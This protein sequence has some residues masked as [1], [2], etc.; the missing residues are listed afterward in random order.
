MITDTKTYYNTNNNVSQYFENKHDMNHKSNS[1]SNNQSLPQENYNND[2]KNI[3]QVKKRKFSNFTPTNFNS[4]L[5][6]DHRNGNYSS[7]FSNS[8]SKLINNKQ[9]YQNPN[10]LVVPVVSAS[11]STM[12]NKRPSLIRQTS[13]EL[14]NSSKTSDIKSK[15]KRLELTPQSATE[16]I[17]KQKQE[18]RSQQQQ[19]DSTKNGGSGNDRN[20]NQL[21]D[22]CYKLWRFLKS[23]IDPYFEHYEKDDE[24]RRIYAAERSLKKRKDNESKKHDSW[25]NFL[26]GI[27]TKKTEKIAK[28]NVTTE[29]NKRSSNN[30]ANLSL[31]NK[32][33]NFTNAKE[34]FEAN[35]RKSY[36]LNL[37]MLFDEGLFKSKNL[38]DGNQNATAEDDKDENNSTYPNTKQ[39]GSSI[40]RRKKFNNRR[41]TKSFVIG[42]D[43]SQSLESEN[44]QA[45]NP[46]LPS[47]ITSPNSS[48]LTV[49]GITT[50]YHN[51]DLTKLLFNAFS[52]T[53]LDEIKTK[54]DGKV[55]IEENDDDDL[56]ITKVQTVKRPFFKPF[57]GISTLKN[58]NDY[59]P[60]MFLTPKFKEYKKILEQK[61]KLQ[62]NIYKLRESKEE[63]HIKPLKDEEIAKVNAIWKQQAYAP[64]KVIT[65][66]ANIDINVNDLGTLRDRVWLNDNI[67]DSYLSLIVER[68]K[69]SDNLPKSFVFTTH[70][71]STLSTKGYNGVRR[72]AKRQKIDVTKL[73]FVFV[74]INVMNSHWSLAVVNNR[75]KKFQYY[76]SLTGS[77]GE[78]LSHLEHYMNQEF[79]RLYPDKE[80]D[81]N[82][83]TF[84]DKEEF[85]QQKNGSDCGVF[86]CTG[87]NFLSKAIDLKFDQSDMPTIRRRMVLEII[88]NKL[89]D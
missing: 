65:T 62:E 36:K 77:G 51:E 53:S 23:T 78:I 40:A 27:K 37:E 33:Y 35:E 25:N 9:I 76:D 6:N 69:N 31:D 86:A 63:K 85:P 2:N 18:E 73:D 75:E 49:N 5:S 38:A 45:F 67:M 12:Q 87:I 66:L 74:P 80:P 48:I 41:K 60:A 56:F 42:S 19:N 30:I 84:V 15:S 24:Y 72:W 58:K 88:N 1:S 7:I 52:N 64:S 43:K 11:S 16:K 8:K 46:I 17:L 4:L 81:Y 79:K 70:F 50:N 54:Q 34:E 13:G 89:F 3:D 20:S 22:V 57:Y 32:D 71:Y 28:K 59:L 29:D 10:S 47:S 39:Y 61:R 55:K 82:T 44:N 68:S 14:K 26:G 21:H 83:W